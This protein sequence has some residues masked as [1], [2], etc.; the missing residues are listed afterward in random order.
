MTS[1]ERSRNGRGVA[2]VRVVSDARALFA[3][4]ETGEVGMVH[5][6][7]PWDLDGAGR[8]DACASYPRLSVEDCIGTLDDARRALVKGGHLYCWAPASDAFFDVCDALKSHGWNRIRLLSWDKG[9]GKGLGAYRNGFEP[10][11]IA[12][13]GPSRGYE[14]QCEYSSLLR[15]RIESA[16]TRKPWPLVKTFLEM[17]SKP[18]ELVVDPFCGTNP[19]AEAIAHL[20]TPRRWLAGDVMSEEEISA[21]LAV[22]AWERAGAS[23]A[24]AR[25]PAA[26]VGPN[27]GAWAF[28]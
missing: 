20:D 24:A 4:L 5:A 3:G 19:L 28:E 14:K 9:T 17:S 25:L 18:G 21:Q 13:N 6:D 1:T 2:S 26:H 8:F 22:R 15:A 7:P 10:I 23:G 11:I 12:S 27:L 16:R